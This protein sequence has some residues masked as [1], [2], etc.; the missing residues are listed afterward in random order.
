M[1]ILNEKSGEK[2]GDS[3]DFSMV[4]QPNCM[5]LSPDGK[6]AFVCAHKDLMIIDVAGSGEPHTERRVDSTI[7]SCAVGEVLI[8]EFLLLA[9][10]EDWLRDRD[11]TGDVFYC[12]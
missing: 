6:A 12:L 9:R 1:S 5:C 3:W 11:S 8:Q 7:N 4:G 2:V 10:E